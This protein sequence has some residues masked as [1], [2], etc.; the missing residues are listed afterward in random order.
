MYFFAETKVLDDVFFGVITVA[1]HFI[2]LTFPSMR[3]QSCHFLPKSYLS[4]LTGT[5]VSNTS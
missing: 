2:S 4:K 1:I 3:F 5:I